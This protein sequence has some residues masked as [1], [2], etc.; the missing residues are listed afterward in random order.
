MRKGTGTALAGTCRAPL[1][2]A[3]DLSCNLA[4]QMPK[5][6]AMQRDG[7]TAGVIQAATLSLPR[8]VPR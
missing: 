6:L 3:D 1:V 7:P 5:M 8:I 4:Q 2:L